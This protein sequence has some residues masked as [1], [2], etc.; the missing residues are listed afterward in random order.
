MKPTRRSLL[1][2]MSALALTPA[3]AG[4]R[5][6]ESTDT[7]EIAAPG[8]APERT[9][10]P[11][12]L[13]SPEGE[14]DWDAFPSGIQVGDVGAESARVSVWMT[15]ESGE[16][17]LAVADGDDWSPVG[18]PVAISRDGVAAQTELR[19][20]APD[21]AYC[22]VARGDGLRSSVSRFRTALA[23]D[24]F[25]QLTIGATSCLHSNRP[26][27][28]M[29]EVAAARPDIFMLLG[30]TVYADGATDLDGYRWHWERALTTQGLIDVS[31]QSSLIATWDDHEVTN[32]FAGLNTPTARVEAALTAFREAIPQREGPGGVLWRK[33][34]WGRTADVF[35]LDGRG[36]RDGEAQYLSREQMDWLKAGLLESEARFK[37]I[38]NSVPV[39][40]YAPIFAQALVRDRWQGYPE[41]R[42]EILDHI[43]ANAVEGVLWITGDFH[44]CTASR[45]DP[46]E[47]VAA[48]L[49]EVM[50]GPGGSFLNIAA[51]LVE[52]NDQFPVIFAEYCSTLIHLDP[53]TGAVR[54]EWIGDDG[55]V[56]GEIDLEI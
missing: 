49:W 9:Q 19:D 7:G 32:D 31:S 30:D 37:L 45:L 3:C 23:A 46:L 34:S 21:T 42:S 51:Q 8:P 14:V 54:V 47:G 27:R 43:V 50:V 52:P 6:K 20:L 40:D 53:G 44:M 1:S 2:G 36:E 12:A 38:M 10:E 18:E 22:I 13:W 41:Q 29:S 4:G 48:D 11:E 33:L 15:A 39:T 17:H 25:R 24:G 26:W 55:F 28:N 35:V 5:G 56:M 16:L